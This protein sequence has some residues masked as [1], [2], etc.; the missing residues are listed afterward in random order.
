MTGRRSGG[1]RVQTLRLVPVG[2]HLL[3]SELI[4]LVFRH[5]SPLDAQGDIIPPPRKKGGR[6]FL[7]RQDHVP[8]IGGLRRDKMDQAL[9]DPNLL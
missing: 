6:K 9:D 4:R 3:L 8:Q 1:P 2:I 5:G 7:F